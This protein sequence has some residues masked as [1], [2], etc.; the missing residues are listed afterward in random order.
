MR[1]TTSTRSSSSRTRAR[2]PASCAPRIRAGAPRPRPPRS[3]AS[4]RR[5]LDLDDPR[6]LQPAAARRI[7][8]PSG[9]TR[10]S[11]RSTRRGAAVL[12][13]EAFERALTAFC[14]EG[15]RSG[16]VFSR[17]TVRRA[18]ADAHERLRDA[19]SAGRE[20]VLELGARPSLPAAV[21]EWRRRPRAS[22]PI[23]ARPRTSNE[24][25]PRQLRCRNR[26][27]S[28]SAS[29]TS[30]RSAAAASGPPPTSRARKAARA[31]RARG[32]RGA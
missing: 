28:P 15:D 23:Q 17:R 2:R 27:R 6:V 19:A 16:S 22:P 3:R 9:S 12:R 11:A 7:R 14:A 21:E 29:S 13:G 30:A 32:A 10:A 1:A 25:L 31:R 26:E 20:L 24:T 18:A 5:R 8:S 4:A